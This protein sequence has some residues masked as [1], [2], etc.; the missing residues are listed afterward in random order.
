MKD[1]VNVVSGG[2]EDIVGSTS[3]SD[4][5]GGMVE[6]FST[7]DGSKEPING[8]SVGNKLSS[9][10]GGF[11][12]GFGSVKGGV[13]GFKDRNPTLFWIGIF[14]IVFM[15][16]CK[17]NIAPNPVTYFRD[18]FNGD[19]PGDRQEPFIEKTVRSQPSSD[20]D[21]ESQVAQLRQLQEKY[22]RSQTRREVQI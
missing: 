7:S 21:I 18:K 4:N 6:E 22:L 16:L 20:F 15:I 14:V 11:K 19:D 5:V 8:G 12:G 9:K 13:I 17:C 2:D 1:A 3:G 10:L